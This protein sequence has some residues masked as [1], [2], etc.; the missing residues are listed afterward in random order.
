MPV[1]SSSSCV[2]VWPSREQV[3]SAARRYAEQL[4]AGDRRVVSVALVGS[5]ARGDH[6]PGSDADLLVVLSRC[7]VPHPQR[8]LQLLP[9]RLPVP[10]DV[11]V[12]TEDE[13]EAWS[14]ERPRWSR[15]VLGRALP[16]ARCQSRAAAAE[17]R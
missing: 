8:T 11:I 14:H 12:L 9:P 7:E 10:T 17:H 3:L 6:G 15:E 4:I 13:V 16:L 1:R 5:Y 2:L